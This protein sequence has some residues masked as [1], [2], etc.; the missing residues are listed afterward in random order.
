[1]VYDDDVGESNHTIKKNTG[2][3]LVGIKEI[4]LEVIADKTKYV[5]MSRD[6]NAG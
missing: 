2:V 6:L 4:S 3:F 1:L 5:I